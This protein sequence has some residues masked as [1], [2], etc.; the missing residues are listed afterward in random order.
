LLKEGKLNPDD[1]YKNYITDATPWFASLDIVFCI[2]DL[3]NIDFLA[4]GN[5]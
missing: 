1:L 2:L 5:Y 4:V 3:P